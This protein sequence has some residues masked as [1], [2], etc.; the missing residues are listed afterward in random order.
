[1]GV[2]RNHASIASQE[3]EVDAMRGNLWPAS[4]EEISLVHGRNSRSEPRGRLARSP[5]CIEKGGAYRVGDAKS[6]SGV[7]NQIAD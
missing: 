6:K 3:C 7:T 2:I 1:M 4:R 5:R